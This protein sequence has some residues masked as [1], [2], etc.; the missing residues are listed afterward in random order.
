MILSIEEILKRNL[1]TNRDFGNGDGLV[2]PEGAAIDIRLGEIWEMDT[3]SEA[4]LYKTTRKTREYKKVAQYS[5]KKSTKFT[6][7][8]MKYYQFISIEVIHVPED[9][10]ARFVARFNLLNNGIMVLGY[11]GDPGWSGQYVTPII[12][13]SGVPF[14]IELGCRWGQFEFHEIKGQGVKYR[15]QWRNGRNF[16]KEAETQV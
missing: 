7:L 15:G 13:L 2:E 4:F 9:L 11:K 12:N 3:A 6:L 1:V 10:V 16:T 8:P 14:E 5:P